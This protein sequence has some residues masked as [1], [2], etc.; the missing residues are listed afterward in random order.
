MDEHIK[1]SFAQRL[2]QKSIGENFTDSGRVKKQRKQVLGEVHMSRIGVCNNCVDRQ[3]GCHA[4]CKKY[5]LVSAVNNAQ[6][7]NKFNKNNDYSDYLNGVISRNE[8]RLRK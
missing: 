2:V 1:Y 8:K 5:M 4:K 3:V 7:E 6:N